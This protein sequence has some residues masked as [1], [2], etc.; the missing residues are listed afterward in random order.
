MSEHA[1]RYGPDLVEG[2]IDDIRQAPSGFTARSFDAS[3]SP[4][5]VLLATG[6]TNR[7]PELDD[8]THSEALARGHLRYCPVCDG[9]E[10]SGLNVAVLGS[11]ARAVSEAEFLRSF[12]DRVTL[13]STVSHAVEAD[14]RRRL[15]RIGA[16]IRL[17]PV[18]GMRLLAGGL[19][20]ITAGRPEIYDAV[21]PALG[22]SIHSRLA[23]ML[24]ATATED[25]CIEVDRHQR[26]TI[27]HLY[28]AGDVV[29]GLD[30]ISVCNGQAAI[31]AVAIRNDL[32][33]EKQSLWP[34][35][36]RRPS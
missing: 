23:K 15:E 9:Y 18:K 30:Q 3:W 4:R 33:A 21:Y 22:S 12:T 11:D 2:R 5:S 24:G 13:I 35:E 31:A 29:Y 20:V 14:L 28:A 32:W 8:H 7:R 36:A 6:V 10:V 25:G 34:H 17:G 19:E 1:R 26:T 27:K 16:T